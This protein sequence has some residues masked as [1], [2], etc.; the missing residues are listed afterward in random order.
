MNIL[1]LVITLFINKFYKIN[2]R[3]KTKLSYKKQK[4]FTKIIKN[5][6]FLSKIN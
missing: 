4:F 2:S 6:R 3:K 1:F 5:L